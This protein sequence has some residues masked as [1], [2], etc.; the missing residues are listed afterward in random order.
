MGSSHSSDS[1]DINPD[2]STVSGNVSI[3]SGGNI[4]AHSAAPVLCCS[5]STSV[6]PP[7]DVDKFSAQTLNTCL[8]DYLST[9]RSLEDANAKLELKV[10]QWV[11]SSGG[12]ASRDYTACFQTISIIRSKIQTAIQLYGSM[13]D[14]QTADEHLKNKSE[15]EP[16]ALQS[17]EADA[18]ELKKILNQLAQTRSDVKTQIRGLEEELKILKKN[19]QEVDLTKAMAKNTQLH[20]TIYSKNQ[21]DLE[22][23]QAKT[24]DLKNKVV[25]GIRTL[26]KSRSEV[27]QVQSSLQSLETQ[28]QSTLDT[29]VL[30]GTLAETLSQYGGQL[31]RSLTQVTTLE[32]QLVQL[33][34]DLDLQDYEYKKLLDTNIHLESEVAEYKRLQG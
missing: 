4:S 34:S 9:M 1:H 5:R 10:R 20:D 11:E 24:Q 21:K 28:L 25:V 29:E 32:G 8:V 17:L 16:A 33:R 3:G 18:A 14:A 30:E 2:G 27:T 19:N 12:S 7:T 13:G 6:R 23:F 31:S 26:Q 15:K 22:A